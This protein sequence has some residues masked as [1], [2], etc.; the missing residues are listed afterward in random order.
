MPWRPLVPILLIALICAPARAELPAFPKD[1]IAPLYGKWMDGQGR[2][3]QTHSIGPKWI[4]DFHGQCPYRYHYRITKIS[5]EVIKNEKSWDIELEAFDPEFLGKKLS[6][7]D[8]FSNELPKHSYVNVSIVDVG[9]PANAPITVIAWE[10]CDTAEHL[11]QFV[12]GNNADQHG[13]GGALRDR[14]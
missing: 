7:K 13:C 9:E 8:C 12:A 1:S 3:P 10:E 14:L 11:Q 5:L 2:N 4:T 6:V